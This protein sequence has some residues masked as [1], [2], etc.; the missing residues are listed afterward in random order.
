MV[1]SERILN[2]FLELVQVDSVSGKERAIADLLKRKLS[3]IGLEVSEDSAG[4][5]VGSDTGN[6]IGKLPGK[7]GA[8]V[9]LLSAHMDTVEPGRGVKPVLDGGVVRS[10]GATVLGSD[11]KAGLVA[12]L[13]VLRLVQE[14]NLEHGGLEVVFTIWEEGGLFGSKNLDY[15]QLSAAA[16]FVLDSDGPPG[17][18]VTRAPWQDQIGVTITGRSAHAGINPEA[19][20]NA[21]MVASQAIAGMK[22]GRIDDET[23]SNIGIISGGKATNIVPDSVTIQGEARSLD[24]TKLAAQTAHICEAIKVTSDKFGAKARIVVDRVYEGFSLDEQALPV[25]LALSAA[26]NL[27]L[28][29]RLKNTGGGSDANIFNSKGIAAAVLGIGMNKV[30]TTEEFISLADLSGNVRYLLEIVRAAQRLQ[31]GQQH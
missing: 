23:T 1:N 12:I 15:K 31:Q 4:R 11:D 17:T 24:P 5:E 21:I 3:E 13:E 19:G 18:I 29:P 30:H 9:L 22:I 27:E 25:R 20:V 26:K 16:G 2:E 6:I 7:S 8:P 10:S 28:T 14:E